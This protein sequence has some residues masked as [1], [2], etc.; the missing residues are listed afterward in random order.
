MER[1]FGWKLNK[2]ICFRTSEGNGVLH[3]VFWGGLYIQQSWLSKAWKKIHNAQIVDIRFVKRNSVNGLVGYLLD[4]YL[5]NQPIERMSYGWGWA[6]LGFCK[7]WKVVKE[8]Y[9][10]MRKGRYKI[11][12]EGK[13]VHDKWHLDQLSGKW[14]AFTPFKM[15]YSQQAVAAWK[16]ILGSHR[17]TSRQTYLFTDK[18]GYNSKFF[19]LETF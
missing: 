18:K 15:R 16:S 6:W 5:L 9:N 2:Y 10:N 7:S 8:H 4:R 13:F 3:I 17:V 14:Y 19:I 11:D 1:K 12:S